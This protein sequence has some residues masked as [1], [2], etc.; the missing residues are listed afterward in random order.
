MRGFLRLTVIKSLGD[1]KLPKSKS[2]HEMPE[3]EKE[4]IRCLRAQS[5]AEIL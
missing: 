3:Q 2:S 1:D 4:K 5:D